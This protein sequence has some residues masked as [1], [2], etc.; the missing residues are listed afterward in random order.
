MQTITVCG[1]TFMLKTQYL[2]Y[3]I[4]KLQKWYKAV[5]LIITWIAQC[6]KCIIRF[7]E[8]VAGGLNHLAALMFP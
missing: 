4:E 7:I 1:M 2:T 8:K 5:C 3:A 6:Q